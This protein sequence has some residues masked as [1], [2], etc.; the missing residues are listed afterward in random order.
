MANNQL[1]SDEYWLPLMQLY[2]KKPVGVKPL[3]SRALVDLALELHIEPSVIYHKLFILRRHGS[4]SLGRL[5][6]KYATNPHLLSHDVKRLRKMRGFG[7]AESF[8]AGVE[9][10]ESWELD[11]K[12]VPDWE[13]LPARLRSGSTPLKPV[14]LIMILD[15]FFRLMPNTMVVETPEVVQLGKLMRVKPQLIVEVLLTF[16]CFDPYLIHVDKHERPL[17]ES[18]SGIWKR[19]GNDDPEMLAALAAQL[20]DYF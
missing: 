1:W 19:F 3:Y 6:E 2:I 14:M 18:C 11:F 20:K 4:S 15:L 10:R 5:W 7:H 9:I 17:H 16:C 12:V 13:L 8:Y